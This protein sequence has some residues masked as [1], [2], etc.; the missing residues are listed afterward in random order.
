MPSRLL[1]GQYSDQAQS[2]GGCPRRCVVA[3]PASAAQRISLDLQAMRCRKVYGADVG[4]VLIHERTDRREALR[5]DRRPHATFELAGAGNVAGSRCWDTRNRKVEQQGIQTS[6]YTNAPVL[7]PTVDC[8]GALRPLE[9]A[10]I[11]RRTPGL[12]VLAIRSQRANGTKWSL[13]PTFRG[14]PG[15]RL[16]AL[17]NATSCVIMYSTAAAASASFGSPP[18]GGMGAAPLIA[19][20]QVWNLL[21]RGARLYHAAWRIGR[22]LWQAAHDLSYTALPSA[23]AT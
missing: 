16:L 13:H 10:A 20:D 17:M 5:N 11:A 12:D 21:C 22:A 19:G 8:G 18:R 6:T 7:A 3:D 23:A 14:K 15:M 4:L 1:Q 9:G 2:A